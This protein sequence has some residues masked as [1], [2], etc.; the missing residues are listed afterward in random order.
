MKGNVLDRRYIVRIGR[1]VGRKVG[2]RD[3][4]SVMMRESVVG[5]SGVVKSVMVRAIRKNVVYIGFIMSKTLR[6]V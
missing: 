2:G 1:I 5:K 4:S 6:Y 3:K